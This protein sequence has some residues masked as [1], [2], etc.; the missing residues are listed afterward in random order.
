M[1]HWSSLKIVAL[2]EK[3]FCALVRINTKSDVDVND[4]L[5]YNDMVCSLLW[6]ATLRH[7]DSVLH[8]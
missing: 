8:W 5:T 2:Q 6:K 1:I 7:Y 4:I 3:I